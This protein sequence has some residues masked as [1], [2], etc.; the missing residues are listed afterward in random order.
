MPE[1]LDVWRRDSVGRA[2]QRLSAP[3]WHRARVLQR[4]RFLPYLRTHCQTR[5][6]NTHTHTHIQTDTRAEFSPR[7]VL[8]CAQSGCL[9]LV[10]HRWLQVWAWDSGRGRAPGFVPGWCTSQHP[11]LQRPGSPGNSRPCGIGS[12][13]L[14]PPCYPSACQKKEDSS[15]AKFSIGKWGTL[16][17]KPSSVWLSKNQSFK[18]ENIL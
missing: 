7:A 17:L 5:S 6:P 16:V 8:V 1:P 12:I 4:H 15:W 13:A 14:P 11:P 2:V 10:P 9:F 3:P 18:G